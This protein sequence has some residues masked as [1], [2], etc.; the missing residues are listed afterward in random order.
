MRVRVNIHLTDWP[1]IG[2]VLTLILLVA[3]CAIF[4]V[5]P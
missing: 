2:A 5:I 4:Q 3:V 1:S